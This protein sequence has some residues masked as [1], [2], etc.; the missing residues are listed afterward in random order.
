MLCGWSNKVHACIVYSQ[1]TSIQAVHRQSTRQSWKH[2]VADSDD[3]DVTA[4]RSWW[5]MTMIRM[6]TVLEAMMMMM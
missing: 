2:P 5:P 1:L 6:M 3:V 4:H